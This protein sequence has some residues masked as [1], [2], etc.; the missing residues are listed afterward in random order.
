MAIKNMEKMLVTNCA[1]GK[2][3]AMV[4]IHIRQD[5]YNYDTIKCSCLIAEFQLMT[6]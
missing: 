3:E 6:F 2:H 5:G 4:F 1:P